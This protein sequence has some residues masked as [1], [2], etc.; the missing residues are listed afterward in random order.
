MVQ[1]AAV[2][3]EHAYRRLRYRAEKA[4]QSNP[5]Q[6]E[7][8]GFRGIEKETLSAMGAFFFAT[9]YADFTDSI[10]QHD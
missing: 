3:N 6:R 9:D 5:L 4:R 8:L 1:R 10:L 2:Q 7:L